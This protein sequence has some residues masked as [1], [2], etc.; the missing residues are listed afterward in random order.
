MDTR[1]T[2]HDTSWT[3]LNGEN[4]YNPYWAELARKPARPSRKLVVPA[5]LTLA[6]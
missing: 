6:S 2:L 4:R 5:R 1:P 3:F